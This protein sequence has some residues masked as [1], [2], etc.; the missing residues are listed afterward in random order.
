M[1]KQP[2]S[3]PTSGQL[4]TRWTYKNGKRR[5]TKTGWLLKK[6]EEEARL[7]KEE[8]DREEEELR[9]EELK[10]NKNKYIPVPAR[11]VPMEPP[12]IASVIATK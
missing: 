3:S 6:E 4:R 2:K 7:R 11:G 12:A 8:V 5:W 1:N 9:H 10:K